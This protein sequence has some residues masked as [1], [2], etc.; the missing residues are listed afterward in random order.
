MAN[1]QD[2]DPEQIV[3]AVVGLW[4]A[5]TDAR[6]DKE[7]VWD[8]CVQN[9]AVHVDESQFDAFPWRCKVADNFSQ[10]TAD[11][12]ASQLRNYLFP[13]NDDYFTLDAL[14]ELANQ[15]IVNMTNYV[16]V[17][18][19]KAK[20]VE[21]V[22]PWL[23]QMAVIGNSPYILTYGKLNAAYTRRVQVINP[24]TSER[25]VQ[26]RA[27]GST[28]W[29]GVSFGTLDAYDVAFD[30]EAVSVDESPLIRRMKIKTDQLGT[31]KPAL[32]N[33]DQLETSGQAPEQA[34]D[35]HKRVRER[36][37]GLNPQVNK[38]AGDE[39]EGTTELLWFYGDLWVDG[40]LY[41]DVRVVA[42]NR[43]VLCLSEA[44]P[45]WA[46]RP[47]GWGGYDPLWNTG[48]AKG[49]LEPVRGIQQLINTFQCQKA[50]VLNLA[51]NGAFAY[52]DDG[53][54]D[55]DRLFLSPMGAIP[56]GNI[57]NIKPL[58][59]TTNFA[60][61]YTEIEQ[62]RGRGERST[63]INR[64]DQ[65]QAPGGRRTAFE[66]NMIR[67]GGSTRTQD[68]LR[69]LANG[70]L[71]HVMNFVVHTLQQFKW[72]S[73]ELPDEALLGEYYA[74]FTGGDNSM[75]RNMEKENLLLGV[76]IASQSPELAA[77]VEMPVLAQKL[78]RILGQDD[79]TLVVTGEKYEQRLR[80]MTQRAQGA[81]AGPGTNGQPPGGLDE[82]L[83]SLVQNMGAQ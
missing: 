50:D 80:Q 68:T 42:G 56:V 47:I 83:L 31:I 33:L 2:A 5:W 73:G 37:F 6:R 34:S 61:P 38:K 40:A 74:Q 21:R 12:L 60:L 79:T 64:F 8:E 69:Q 13:I 71:E 27:K 22:L 63:G 58:Q 32:K 36:L 4:E 45:F 77:A 46:G 3:Q 10:E 82:S 43:E 39:D 14:D 75:L 9:Y 1:I 30:P 52:V 28:V 7:K 29:E 55:P 53:I 18:M 16:K 70:P 81:Q 49:A 72:G 11:T 25:K 59:P 19:T 57:N 54:I 62:L 20:F 15:H 24:V 76:Q 48:Y 65:G 66:A 67:S 78:W 26:V 17:A 35:A 51:I 41:E 44:N 23:K